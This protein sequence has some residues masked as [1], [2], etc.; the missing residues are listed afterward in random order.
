M[1]PP[2][3]EAV[4]KAGATPTIAIGCGKVPPLNPDEIE[5]KLGKGIL[6]S[7]IPVV[8]N[9]V[10]KP[11]NYTYVGMTSR[12]CPCSCSTRSRKPMSVSA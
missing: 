4:R 6:S 9:D 1:L 5:R 11:E 8:C 10:T 3:L 7:G 2:I 12:V